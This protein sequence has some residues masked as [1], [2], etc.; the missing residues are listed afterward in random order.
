MEKKKPK[1]MCEN[2]ANMF[3]PV[4]VERRENPLWP[5]GAWPW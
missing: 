1:N 3:G 4:L 5:T 2:A